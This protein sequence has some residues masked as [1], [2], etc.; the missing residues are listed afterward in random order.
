[1]TFGSRPKN[2]DKGIASH[3]FYWYNLQRWRKNKP[4]KKNAMFV[5][6][7]P[8]LR[9][10]LGIKEVAIMATNCDFNRSSLLI[11]QYQRDMESI[12]V[13]LQEESQDEREERLN[14]VACAWSLAALC[15][16]SQPELSDTPLY[17]SVAI[18]RP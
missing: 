15:F 12:A 10:G 5:R 8:P 7:F 13:A 2:G 3:G 9:L 16:Q 6:V 17:A 14:L 1:M 18:A 11:E 4:L